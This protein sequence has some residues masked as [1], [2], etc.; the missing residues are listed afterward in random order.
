MSGKNTKI[1][2]RL[3]SFDRTN[4]AV[5][6]I[7]INILVPEISTTQHCWDP[8]WKSSCML[9]GCY[10][11]RIRKHTIITG[12]NWRLIKNTQPHQEANFDVKNDDANLNWQKMT[13]LTRNNTGGCGI[14]ILYA[15]RKK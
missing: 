8:S 5:Y 2:L 7:L 14:I 13:T 12:L 1:L 10:Y 11:I 15:S 6:N 9:C 3:D 4:I